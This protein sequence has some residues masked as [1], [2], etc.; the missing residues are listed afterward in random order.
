MELRECY[1][2]VEESRT[3]DNTPIASLDEVSLE[4][5]DKPS[6][7]LTCDG[8]TGIGAHS[9]MVTYPYEVANRRLRPIEYVD[10]R[11]KKRGEI[12][13]V[14]SM[15]TNWKLVKSKDGT[16]QDILYADCE[17]DT[18]TGEVEFKIYYERFHFDGRK[19]V[20]YERAEKGYWEIGDDDLPA[21]SKFP[22]GP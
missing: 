5:P 4:G 10:R 21:L 13:L 19:W 17:P 7:F 9:G 14:S 1:T 22:A 20:R 6:Y 16:S 3:F 8:N 2:R 15:V 12:V 11:S 18:S